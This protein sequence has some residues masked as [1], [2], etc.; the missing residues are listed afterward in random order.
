MDTI[1]AAAVPGAVVALISEDVSFARTEALINASDNARSAAHGTIDKLLAHLP[2]LPDSFL[3][4]KVVN[5]IQKIAQTYG[6]QTTARGEAVI[7]ICVT[8]G[9][10]ADFP[11]LTRQLR[12]R[13]PTHTEL[14]TVV[15]RYCLSPGQ[16]QDETERILRTCINKVS[17]Q[18]DAGTVL[19]RELRAMLR[20]A[21]G[22]PQKAAD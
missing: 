9:S 10:I 17:K 1:S 15:A 2:A 16:H 6:T 12:N 3:R 13:L 20:E 14:T 21:L 19:A 18:S 7:K 22:G 11:A 8:S 4:D 5:V